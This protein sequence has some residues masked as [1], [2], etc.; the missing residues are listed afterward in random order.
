MKLNGTVTADQLQIRR[1][2]CHCANYLL[3]WTGTTVYT[4]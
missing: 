3:T 2:N 4:R 1:T